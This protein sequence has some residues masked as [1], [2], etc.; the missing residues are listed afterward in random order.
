MGLPE[1]E[2]LPAEPGRP[3]PVPPG[4]QLLGLLQL[5][6]HPPGEPV[7]VPR[8]PQGASQQ[9]QQQRR[10]AQQPLHAPRLP[11]RSLGAR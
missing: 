4:G 6:G 5:P 11:S 10:R 8:V 1:A 3:L 2:T 7:R 9:D